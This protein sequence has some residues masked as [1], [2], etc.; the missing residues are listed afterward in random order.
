MAFMENRIMDVSSP[1]VEQIVQQVKALPSGDLPRLDAELSGLRR[2][3]MR[4]LTEAAR[5]RT[6]DAREQEL[7]DAVSQAVQATRANRSA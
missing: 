4:G 3:R 2:T 7:R 6:K 1:T 5:S